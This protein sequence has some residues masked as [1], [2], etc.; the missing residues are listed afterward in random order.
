MVRMGNLRAIPNQTGLAVKC[1]LLVAMPL[2]K[3]F[4]I[5]SEIVLRSF[6]YITL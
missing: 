2:N 1:I 4:I 3:G 6:A 5:K